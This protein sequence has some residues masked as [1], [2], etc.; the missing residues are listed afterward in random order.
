[1]AR[2]LLAKHR[3]YLEFNKNLHEMSSKK[4]QRIQLMRTS[5]SEDAI[6]SG[7]VNEEARYLQK[8]ENDFINLL[9]LSEPL[10]NFQISEL[11]KLS[12]FSKL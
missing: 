4:R 11:L 2:E 3:R 10:D 8:T 5:N 9:R 1:M 7:Q 6:I 12:E